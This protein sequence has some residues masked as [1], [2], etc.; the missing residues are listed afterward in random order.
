LR[1][2]GDDDPVVALLTEILIPEVLAATW[3]LS[4]K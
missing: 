2:P 3:W 1:Y 4:R